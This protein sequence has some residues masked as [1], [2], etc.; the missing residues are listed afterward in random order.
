MARTT[1]AL[2]VAAFLGGV[3]WG[4]VAEGK[5]EPRKAAVVLPE[6]LAHQGRER[7]YRL[8][9]P[10]GYDKAK[11]A[12][13]V[14]ALHGGGGTADG[15]DR[16]TGAQFARE[17]DKRGWVVVFPQGVAKGWNDGRPLTSRRD[18]QRKGVDDVAFLGALI[19]HL[20]KTRGIDRTRVYAT[21]ISNGG[22]MSFRLGLE[23]SAR[24]AAIAP[25]TANLAK[26]HAGKRPTHPVGLLVI[27]G[28][29]DPLVPYA[30]GQV[31]V[32][33]K[34]RGAIFSTD[35]SLVRWAALVGCGKAGKAVALPDTA[36]RDGARAYRQ[37]WTPCGR[38]AH[39]ELIRIEGGGHTWPGGQQYLPKLLVGTTCRD[40]D[41]VPVIFDF[42]ARHRRVKSP[43]RA[44]ARKAR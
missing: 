14:L 25:V 34:A 16:S 20:H 7:T 12:P 10:K 21:G 17:A 31:K 8:L 4:F 41:A 27:N 9:L 24:I 40:F 19:D 37:A 3:V 32:L 42:F 29:K 26:V 35:E 11:P 28:T 33:G 15:M 23:L 5:A 22:F 1:L 38:G 13:L 43:A 36:P 2:L 39:V 6:T 44:P 30:G 18:K